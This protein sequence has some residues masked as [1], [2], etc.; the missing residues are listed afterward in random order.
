MKG[1]GTRTAKTILAKK[2]KVGRLTLL[3]SKTCKKLSNQVSYWWKDRVLEKWDEI[4]SRNRLIYTYGQLI[5][6]T[7]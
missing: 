5:Y 2:S 6:N 4:E 7:V 3:D 1:R